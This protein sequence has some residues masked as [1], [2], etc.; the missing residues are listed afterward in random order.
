MTFQTDGGGFAF[1]CNDIKLSFAASTWAMKLSQLPRQ[2]GVC[3]I[4]TYSLPDM[5]YV[6]TQFER[7]PYDIWL[8]AN[9]KFQRRAEEIKRAFPDIRVALHP[10]VHTKLLLIEPGTI[11]LS[12]AN[13]GSSGWHEMGIGL[14]HSAA[15]NEAR[16]EFDRLWV[17]CIE[18]SN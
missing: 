6:R 17:E 5:S 15:H 7:R 11:W 13:F 16:K 10:E 1:G 18:A 14:H 2:K 3:R 9:A 8:V 12:S 4:I